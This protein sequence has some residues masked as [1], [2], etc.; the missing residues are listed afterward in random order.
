LSR[1]S[2][3]AQQRLKKKKEKKNHSQRGERITGQL[4]KAI[5]NQ[6]NREIT[7]SENQTNREIT[8]SETRGLVVVW[9]EFAQVGI[10]KMVDQSLFGWI[11]AS[12][13]GLVAIYNLVAKKNRVGVS[14]EARSEGMKSFTTT[15][16]GECRSGNGD[17]DVIIVGAGVAGGALAHTLAKV[18]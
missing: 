18:I 14:S 8:A 12:V 13:L 7:A 3:Q 5:E 11:F 16:K 6:T 9:G 17:V 1:K 15:T 4:H 2:S 10:G